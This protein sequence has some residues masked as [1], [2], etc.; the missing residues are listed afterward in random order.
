MNEQMRHL[1]AALVEQPDQVEATPLTNS[2]E[3][4]HSRCS[5]KW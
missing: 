2:R 1:V 4:M 5:K 3:I